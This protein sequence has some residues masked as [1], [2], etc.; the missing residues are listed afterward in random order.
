MRASTH[1]AERASASFDSKVTHPRWDKRL[2][3]LSATRS[4]AP[5]TCVVARSVR[6]NAYYVEDR[7]RACQNIG[8]VLELLRLD[9]VREP[10]QRPVDVVR[11]QETGLS[12]IRLPG[13]KP[14][15]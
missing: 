11:G 4:T 13:Q 7:S 2:P 3:L 15:A 6:R 14:Q 12:R 9:L 10:G 8:S 1:S 5:S